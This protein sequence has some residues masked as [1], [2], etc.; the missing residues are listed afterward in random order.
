MFGTGVIQLVT[1]T[2][3]HPHLASIVKNENGSL[4][5]TASAQPTN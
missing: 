1:R 5:S 3:R 2:A 4:K